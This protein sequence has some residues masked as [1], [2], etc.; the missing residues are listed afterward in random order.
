MKNDVFVLERN[1]MAEGGE[2]V[3]KVANG[4]GLPDFNFESRNSPGVAVSR[5]KAVALVL[6]DDQKP[7]MVEYYINARSVTENVVDALSK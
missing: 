4:D 1:I 6:G 7:H 5:N 3:R 2:S